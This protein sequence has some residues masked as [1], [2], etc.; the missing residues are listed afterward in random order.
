MGFGQKETRTPHWR[1]VLVLFNLMCFV[2]CP[3]RLHKP[4]ENR[5]TLGAG[6]VALGR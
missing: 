6:G 4:H 2:L 5:R 1:G 3:K